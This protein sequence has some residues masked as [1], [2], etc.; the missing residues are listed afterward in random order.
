MS[1]FAEKI[2]LKY[3]DL[4]SSSAIYGEYSPRNEK[5]SRGNSIHSKV[6]V[7]DEWI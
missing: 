2:M 7:P 3:L 5:Y 4:S 1:D 6:F